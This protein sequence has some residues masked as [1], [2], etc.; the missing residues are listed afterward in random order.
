MNGTPPGIFDHRSL[1]MGREHDQPRTESMGQ[2]GQ[3]QTPPGLTGTMEP[4]PDHGETSYKG[5][6]KLAGKAAVITGGDTRSR[7]GQRDEVR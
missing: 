6:G 2:P 5:S 1:L 7:A 4:T 3:Q